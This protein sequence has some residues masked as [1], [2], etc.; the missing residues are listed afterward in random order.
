MV[1]GASA[2]KLISFSSLTEVA[3]TSCS[4]APND[5]PGL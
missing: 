5:T 2:S 3:L 4:T 1:G